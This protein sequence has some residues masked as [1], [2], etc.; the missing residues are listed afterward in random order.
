MNDTNKQANQAE[1]M[2]NEVQ[3]NEPE[4]T[5]KKMFTQEEVNGFVQNRINRM[6]GQIEKEAKGQYE[7]KLAELNAREMKILVKEKL[8]ERNM[9]KEL[10]DVITC[11][12]EAELNSKLDALQKIY[13]ANSSSKEDKPQQQQG[14]RFGADNNGNQGQGVDPVRKAMGLN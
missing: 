14:F 7:Q 2:G 9:P 11:N 10:A 3:G 13:G 6:R 12:D 1:N 4:N 5:G 8:S